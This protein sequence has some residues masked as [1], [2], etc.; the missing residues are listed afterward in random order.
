[1]L[2]R[3]HEGM[4]RE[5]RFASDASHELRT[6]LAVLKSELEVALLQ[7]GTREQWREAVVSAAEETEQVI[8]LAED[9]LVL[10]RAQ[11]GHLALSAEP[12]DAGEVVRLSSERIAPA[13]AALGRSFHLEA[14]AGLAIL[15]D[16]ARLR[17]MLDNLL[18]N[19]VQHGDGTITVLTRVADGFIEVHVMD[20]GAGFP[21]GFLPHA[22]ARFARADHA[23][24][25]GGAGLGLA[26]VES[27][28][29]SHGGD[30]G[31]A[32]RPSG[33]ADVWVRLPAPPRRLRSVTGADVRSPAAA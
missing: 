3:L 21:E 17:Q 27:L 5:R 15:A 16:R 8:A 32:N 13:L 24:G 18:D 30:A 4:E 19:A 22:F 10:A 23:R 1:M 6:P 11:D 26:I 9:L 20:E 2:D 25:R 29:R 14:E 31:A 12:L 28:A 7:D 33:G